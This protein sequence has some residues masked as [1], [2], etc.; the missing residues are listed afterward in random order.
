M[1]GMTSGMLSPANSS[2]GSAGASAA[3]GN[4]NM[5]NVSWGNYNAHNSNAN[6]SDTAFGY[7]TPERGDIQGQFT[8]YTALGGANV[9]AGARIQGM[10]VDQSDI[11]VGGTHGAQVSQG[12][13]QSSGTSS[14]LTMASNASGVA[15]T[16]GGYR[17]EEGGTARHAIGTAV[18]NAFGTDS[19]FGKM[20]SA[21]L[22]QMVA[23]SQGTN[24]KTGQ[25]EGFSQ[26]SQL[27][28]SAQA[29][30]HY[31]EPGSSPAATGAPGTGVPTASDN[32]KGAPKASGENAANSGL[33]H[34]LAG[35]LRKS[36]HF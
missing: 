11:G 33:G 22:Q 29:G 30:N 21:A 8:G 12:V 6:H 2:A 25:R 14:S 31:S 20:L 35:L 15:T 13:T 27:G 19:S 16:T 36:V 23:Q 26:T 34:K 17:K 7:K 5:G 10:K 28:L 1:S 32:V 3:M 24:S 4:Q 18:E 9:P